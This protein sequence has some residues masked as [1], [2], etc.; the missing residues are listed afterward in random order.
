LQEYERDGMNHDFNCNSFLMGNQS[1]GI[2]FNSQSNSNFNQNVYNGDINFYNTIN[3]NTRKKQN[4]NLKVN[5]NILK[6]LD[7]ENKKEFFEKD[8]FKIKLTKK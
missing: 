6:L 8:K 7:N 2:L 5:L 1:S 4:P 3:K